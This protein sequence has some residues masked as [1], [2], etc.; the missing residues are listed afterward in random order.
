MISSLTGSLTRKAADGIEVT[1]NGIGYKLAIPLSTF[2]VLPEPFEQVRLFT[3]LN[4]KENALELIGF[5]TEP[6]RDLFELLIS[7]SGVGVKLG[8]TI[9][10][11]I[12]SEELMQAI[13]SE[14]KVSL[15]RISG[16][17]AKTAGRLVL[18]LKE[19][20]AK[21]CS[22]AAIATGG[23]TSK[24]QE[25]IMALEALGYGRYE[26]KRAV[27]VAIQGLGTEVSAEELIRAALKVSV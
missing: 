25:A 24:S 1:V 13:V 4:V 14:D 5:A 16:V 15:S 23:A 9:M 20:V 12:E 8:L 10:S 11:G 3:Y 17:G 18:E 19:K 27:D 22:L 26:A 7:V 2:R 21:I 6:E